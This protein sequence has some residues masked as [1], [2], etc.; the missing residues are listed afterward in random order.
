MLRR[1][2]RLRRRPEES[3]MNYNIRTALMITRWMQ[4]GKIPFLYDRVLK[5]VCKAA[6]GDSV[7]SL[8]GGLQSQLGAARSFRNEV[9]GCTV[10]FITPQYKRRKLGL[11]YD[12]AGQQRATWERPF[13]EAWCMHWI[14]KLDVRSSKA[15]W[16]NNYIEFAQEVFRKWSL[17]LPASNIP[18]AGSW[19]FLEKV[20]LPSTIADMPHFPQNPR[21]D[22]RDTPSG[23]LW[24]QTDNQQVE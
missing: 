2:L 13:V 15:A 22:N 16:M 9:W 19:G 4:L 14:S 6:W 23:R 20:S 17:H 8:G 18:V 11:T 3:F 1:L 5:S 21:E 12:S 10:V 7:F 24:L